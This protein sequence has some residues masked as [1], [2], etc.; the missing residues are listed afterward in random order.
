MLE[1]QIRWGKFLSWSWTMIIYAGLHLDDNWP[2]LSEM[3][4]FDRIDLILSAY[5]FP[6]TFYSNMN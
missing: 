3:A 6:G 2:G 5:V 4:G 1:K